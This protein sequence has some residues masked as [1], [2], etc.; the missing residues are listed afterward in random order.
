[1]R[2]ENSFLSFFFFLNTWKESKFA[3]L[4]TT[5]STLATALETALEEKKETSL[6][7]ERLKANDK[8]MEKEIKDLKVSVCIVGSVWECIWV[9]V[10]AYELM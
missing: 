6:N 1:M 9:Q 10:S 5:N 7:M 4:E 3:S 2:E 8:R